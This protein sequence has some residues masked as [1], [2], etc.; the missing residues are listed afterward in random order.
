MENKKSKK[1]T[2]IITVIIAAVILIGTA[3]VLI[4]SGVFSPKID[5]D[6][7]G[8]VGVISD[9]WDTGLKEE[10]SETKPGTQIPGYSTAEMKEGDTTLTLSIGNPKANS[11][12]FFATL[13]LQNGDV[14]YES[15]LLEPGQG[16]TEIP[17][18]HTLSKGTYDAA[19]VYKCVLLDE[20]NTPL[21]AAESV[22]KLIVN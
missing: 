12:G 15:E 9:D 6:H 16:L 19:V 8:V 2:V 14:L 22:F 3:G 13:K 4:F 20:E 5:T 10:S 11:V 1:K 18:T 17:L 21:N 7:K